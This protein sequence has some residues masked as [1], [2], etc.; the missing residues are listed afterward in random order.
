ME[1]PRRTGQGGGAPALAR[2]AARGALRRF[3]LDGLPVPH[4]PDEGEELGSWRIFDAFAESPETGRAMLRAS[5]AEALDRGVGYC[6]LVHGGGE[7]WVSAARRDAPPIFARVVPY[8][9]LVNVP[10]GAPPRI[11]HLCVDVRAL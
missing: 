4:V 9:L 3:P 11:A 1:R 5:A 7:A 2:R 6:Y 10:G 8:R